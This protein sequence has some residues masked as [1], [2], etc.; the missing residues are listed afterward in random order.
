MKAVRQVLLIVFLV[1][2]IIIMI[3]NAQ[4]T[5]FKFL[6][7]SYQVSQLLLV[8]IVLAIG[9]LTGFIIAKLPRGKN[10]D[11]HPIPPVRR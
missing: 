1:L 7:W 6:N 11:D 10:A 8:V 9:F 5:T 2:V 3:Q 4:P